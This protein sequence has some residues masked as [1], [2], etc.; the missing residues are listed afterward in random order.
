MMYLF[1]K[2]KINK[3]EMHHP[4]RHIIIKN[5]DVKLIDF[6]RA[7]YAK[8]PKNVT[9]FCQFIISIQQELREKKINI[10][11]EKIIKL[12]KAY[13]TDISDKNFKKIKEIL[14]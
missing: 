12:G 10:E 4:V 9:Q 5:H 1:D 3:E 14:K 6:E 7:N 2:L 11:M 8:K 13:K